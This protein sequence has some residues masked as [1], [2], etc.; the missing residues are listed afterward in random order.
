[1]TRTRTS[2]A[3]NRD[4]EFSTNLVVALKQHHSAALVARREIITRM[5]KLDSRDNIRCMRDSTSTSIRRHG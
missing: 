5:V 2:K 4:P 3:A 1:M